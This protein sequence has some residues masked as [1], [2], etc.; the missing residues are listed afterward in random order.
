MSPPPQ[1]AR[2]RI[3]PLRDRA[4][5]EADDIV[6]GLGQA[7]TRPASSSG[8][9]S[10]IDLAMAVRAQPSHQRV[11]VGAVDRRFAGRIDVRDDHRVGV[12]EAGA[13]L[14]EQVASRV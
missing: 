13:E 7:A 4:G 3:G 6:A 9:S 11:A 10:G 2:Q 12:V 8:P 1:F 5:A 14:L